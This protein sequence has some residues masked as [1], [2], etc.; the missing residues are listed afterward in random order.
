MSDPRSVPVID[1]RSSWFCENGYIWS[2]KDRKRMRMYS[3]RAP[4][5]RGKHARHTG[6]LTPYR[7]AI[8]ERIARKV[9][10]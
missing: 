5:V 9:G 6:E 1:V 10:G 8:R 3:Q 2:A 4:L 7:L